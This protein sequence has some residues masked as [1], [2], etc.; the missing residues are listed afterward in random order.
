MEPWEVPLSW[1]RKSNPGATVL[2]DE[3]LNDFAASSVVDGR[4]LIVCGHCLLFRQE[5]PSRA[6][7]AARVRV[8]G[9]P[10]NDGD[11]RPAERQRRGGVRRSR[12]PD[13]S[14]RRAIRRRA[15]RRRRARPRPRCRRLPWAAERCAV[16]AYRRPAPSRCRR[17]CCAA[18]SRVTSLA[19]FELA[20]D[21]RVGTC[22]DSLAWGGPN[23]GERRRRNSRKVGRRRRPRR[24]RPSPAESSESTWRW[25]AGKVA[26]RRCSVVDG[27]GGRRG[28]RAHGGRGG[29]LTGSKRGAPAR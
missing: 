22:V 3:M 9:R 4:A 8:V 13:R 1:D 10:P 7:D 28:D 16:L 15:R 2:R 25:S 20:G 12:G 14:G 29:S 11:A 27:R 24:R 23:V 21:V 5:A 6:P 19:A 26:G 17:S 18:A